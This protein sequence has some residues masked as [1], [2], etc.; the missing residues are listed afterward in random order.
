MFHVHAAQN[1]AFWKL[2]RTSWHMVKVSYNWE[3]KKKQLTISH[4]SP[5]NSKN[6]EKSTYLRRQHSPKA[7]ISNKWNI[8]KLLSPFGHL[9]GLGGARKDGGL[10]R[11]GTALLVSFLCLKPRQQCLPNL[12]LCSKTLGQTVLACPELWHSK[13]NLEFLRFVATE[14]PVR[15]QLHHITGSFSPGWNTR[16]AEWRMKWW[17]R[18]QDIASENSNFKEKPILLP[19]IH[20]SHLKSYEH[21]QRKHY[22]L[23]RFFFPEKEGKSMFK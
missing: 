21:I 8:K 20:A 5:A 19:L 16:T 9:Q 15:S 12:L 4:A 17:S 23:C 3:I 18:S 10:R 11:A 6:L 22:T 1:T 7:A 14:V 2:V 13:K